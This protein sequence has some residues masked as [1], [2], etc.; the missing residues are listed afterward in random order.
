MYFDCQFYWQYVVILIVGDKI[1]YFVGDNI[2]DVIVVGK[3]LIYVCGVDVDLDFWLLIGQYIVLEVRW[4]VDG[5]CVVFGIQFGVY[6][7][8]GDQ[9]WFKKSGMV[10]SVNNV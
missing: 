3:G 1:V 10:K 7:I 4:D 8:S 6:F 2:L 9:F 5:E